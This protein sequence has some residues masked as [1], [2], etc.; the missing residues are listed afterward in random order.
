M[1]R[2]FRCVCIAGALANVA[3]DGDDESVFLG[4]PAADDAQVRRDG[5]NSG[6][7][8]GTGGEPGR[9]DAMPAT[10]DRGAPPADVAAPTD[11]RVSA[12]RS[13]DPADVGLVGGDRPAPPMPDALVPG[14]CGANADCPAG[15]LCEKES[16]QCDALG[17]PG[18]CVLPPGACPALDI[19]VCGCDGV[20]YQNGCLRQVALVASASNGAC[21]PPADCIAAGG[22]GAVVPDSPDCCP[23][24][25]RVGCGG[26]DRGDECQ[27]DCV[28]GFG[29]IAA[30][31]GQC[32]AGENRCNSDDCRDGGGNDDDRECNAPID[33]LGQRWNIRCFGHWSCDRGNCVA[34]CGEPCGDGVCRVEDG[35]DA[36][37][38]ARECR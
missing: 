24:L 18:R 31:D 16:G 33:C 38:C 3:C 34:A 11:L 28:G 21:E 20:T 6:D 22:V 4:P 37:T 15:Q 9:P 19:P 8:G 26:P 17:P 1:T 25:T 14:G 35:E 32:G 10:L 36:S 7:G 12:D 30:G 29:C 27:D 23:G 13:E 2:F 5:A